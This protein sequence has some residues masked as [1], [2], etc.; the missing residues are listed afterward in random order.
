MKKRLKIRP[1][2]EKTVGQ[3]SSE[4]LQKPS[5][6]VNAIDQGNAMLNDYMKNVIECVASTRK[7]ADGDFYVVVLTKREHL[8]K[9]VMRNYYF[10][11]FTCPTPNYDQAVFKY[12]RDNE[13]IDFLWVIPT[14]DVCLYY[15]ENRTLIP[16]EEWEL[17][18]YVLDFQDGSLMKLAKKL[19]G[20][21]IDSPI[22]E[23]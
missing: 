12:N 11:R 3:V 5:T 8:M 13:T 18:K 22:L 7:I 16:K 10:A 9:N 14:K 15:L 4:L 19:N 20:E 2:S 17:L 23:T 21:K 6:P 1:K